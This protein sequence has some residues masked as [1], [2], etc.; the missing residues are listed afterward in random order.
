M[1]KNPLSDAW[2]FLTAA[3]DDYHQLGW[4]GVVLAV[5]YWI[6]LL[7]SIALAIRNWK[8]DPAQR[9]ATHCT[10]FVVRVLIGTMWFEGM[11]WKLPLP[12]SGGLQYWTEQMATRAAFQFHRDFVTGFLLPNLKILGPFVFLTEFILAVS[13]ILGLGV[14][15]AGLIGIVFVLHLWLGIYLPGVPAEWPWSYIF[16]AMLMFFLALHAA[17]RSLG[18][19][20][21]LRRNV[22]SV[23]DGTDLS[24]KILKLVG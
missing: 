23:G 9:S 20:A 1:P 15:L 16:L 6:L 4:L 13:L 12:A 19:D 5:V 14:R 17:G 3:T 21:W 7:S 11:L 24:G 10:T 8:E 2:Q 22:A 18:L